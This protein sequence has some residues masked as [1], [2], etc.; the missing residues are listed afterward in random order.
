MEKVKVVSIKDNIIV[1]D[2]GVKLFSYHDQDCCEHHDLEMND[3]TLC[4]FDG[5]EFDLTN[6]NF[7]NRIEDYGIELVPTKGHSVKIPGYGY[8][9]GYYSSQMDL[10]LEKEGKYIKRYDISECQVS[11]Y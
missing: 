1:F 10:V 9:N 6:D 11:K 2:N 4:D 7:F 3:L 8:N 5:L